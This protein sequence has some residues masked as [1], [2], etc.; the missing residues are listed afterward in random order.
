VTGFLIIAAVGAAS[1]LI[2][3]SSAMPSRPLR[4]QRRISVHRAVCAGEQQ[5]GL[6]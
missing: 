5:S 2:Q 3:I 6:L 1:A 4:A